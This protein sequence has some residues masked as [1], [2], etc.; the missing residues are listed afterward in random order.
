MVDSA[1][2]RFIVTSALVTNAG[3]YTPAVRVAQTRETIRSIR[4][5][6]PRAFILLA[7]GGARLNDMPSG[8]DELRGAVDGLLD[9]TADQRILDL[10][11]EAF[12]LTHSSTQKGGAVG[13]AKTMAE[14]LLMIG[15]LGVLAQLPLSMQGGRVFKLSGRYQLAPLFDPAFYEA[16]TGRY[17]FACRRRSW[18]PNALQTIGVEHCLSSCL[19]SFDASSLAEVT[20]VFQAMLRE[21]SDA[22]DGAYI[23]IEHLLFKY[24]GAQSIIEMP[25]MHL[26]GSVASTGVVIY[27]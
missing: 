12:A 1:I 5:H 10:H 15:A 13:F 11:R 16:A 18:V 2:N 17:V 7:E 9:M 23:D 19:W 3:V 24:I 20:A 26:M 6:F 25:Q 21:L 4:R 8:W 27:E 14:L 22:S